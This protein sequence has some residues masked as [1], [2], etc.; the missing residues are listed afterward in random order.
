MARSAAFYANDV[1]GRPDRPPDFAGSVQKVATGMAS[2]DSL[3][4]P[5][6][7][8]SYRAVSAVVVTSLMPDTAFRH[9][10]ISDGIRR[11]AQGLTAF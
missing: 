10:R 11:A 3:F 9:D 4:E 5:M 1:L 7:G 2:M 8:G 6:Q